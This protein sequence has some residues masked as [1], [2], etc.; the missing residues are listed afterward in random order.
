MTLSKTGIR[1]KTWADDSV[2]T[3]LL[4][5]KFE[6]DFKKMIANRCATRGFSRG[7]R[8]PTQPEPLDLNFRK[9][10]SIDKLRPEHS[11]FKSHSHSIKIYFT[12][13]WCAEYLVHR[14]G[15]GYML[16]RW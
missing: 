6:P 13:W 14:N 3:K 2:L 12:N 11:Y 8:L 15:N 10:I 7:Q 1:P 5:E 16:F 4:L 9:I